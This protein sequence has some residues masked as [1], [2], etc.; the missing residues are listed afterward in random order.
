M[1]YYMGKQ[2]TFSVW[3]V[4]F[5]AQLIKNIATVH[6]NAVVKGLLADW[7]TVI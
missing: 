5:K 1:E 6:I 4:A 7:L 2:F 3:I